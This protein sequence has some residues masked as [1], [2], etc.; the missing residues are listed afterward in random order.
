MLSNRT[1]LVLV[2]WAAHVLAFVFL[3]HLMGPMVVALAML[4]VVVTG[5]LFGTWGGLFSGLMA[6]LLNVLLMGLF[7]GTSR[8]MMTPGGLFGSVHI[9]LLGAGVGWLRNM[10]KQMRQ[11]LTERK[12]MEEALRE[13][14]EMLCTITASAQ[15]AIIMIDEKGDVSFWNE[16]AEKMFGYT[17]AEAMGRNVH[18]LIA[19]ERYHEAH[20]RAF[21]RFQDT[22]QGSAVGKTTELVAVRKGG[23]E[24]PVELSLSAVRL[25]GKWQAISVIRDITERKLV[26]EALQAER[27]KAQKYLDVAGVM[28]VALNTAGEATL[29]NKR[30]C[31]ILGYEPEEI[32]GKNWF[33]NFLPARIRDEVRGVFHRLI[34]G[35]IAPVEYFENPVLTREREERIIAWHN[36][37][38][39]D[40]SGN[41]VG[42][43]GSGE[44]I[45]ER[46]QAEEYMQR[47]HQELATLYALAQAL[48]SS[49]ELQDLL[50]EAL[51]RTVHALGFAGGLIT[52]VDG[53]K[54]DQELVS[55]I[56]VSPACVERLRNEGL[57]GTLCDVVYHN[58]EVL[59][60]EDL[61]QGSSLDTSRLVEAGIQAY[62]G[63]PIVHKDR[64]LGVLCLFDTRPHPVAEVDKAL[65]TSIGQQIGVAVENARLF[66][67]TRRRA[68]Q[69]AALSEIGRAVG[70]TLDLDAV[71]H[72]ILE[73]LERVI[74]YDTASLW[75]RE[76][77]ML[78]IYAV[79]G[80]EDP[81]AVVGLTVSIQEDELFQ[82]IMRTRR[83]LII[84]DAQQD[85]RFH[86]FAGT[87]WVRS[88]L[89]VPLLSKNEVVG[90]LTIDRSEPDSHTAETA[91][92]ALAFGQQ[93]AMAIENARLF[94]ETSQRVR[95][96]QVLNDVSMAAVSG[97]SLDE[98]LKAAA[99]AI[100]NW[101]RCDHVGI[102]LLDA[103][104]GVLR[105]KA[106]ATAGEFPDD[107]PE[108]EWPISQ[109]ITGWVVHH[110]EPVL[111][112]D[113]RLDPRYPG[114]IGS[115]VSELCVPL[116][117]GSR[118]IGTVNVESSQLNA[119]TEDDRRLLST[120]ANN[121]AMRIEQARLLEETQR[122]MREFQLLH[123]V[124]LAAAFGVG[125]DETLQAAAEALADGLKGP[126]VSLMLLDQDS[127]LLQVK[128]SVG[129]PPETVQNLRLGV[130]EG[131]SGWV[132]QHGEP[133]L[134]PDVR[135]DPRY[136]EVA[137]E[138]RSE[139][140]VPLIVS[141]QVIGVL[142]IESPVVNAFTEED[143]RLLSILAHSLALL[144]ERARLFEESRRARQQAE[145][146]V[147]ELQVLH[148]LSRAISGTLDLNQVL[149]ALIG[150]LSQEMGFTHIALH[151][152]DEDANEIRTVRAA[153]LAR[154]ME[155]LVRSLDALAGDI[156]MD[157]AHRGEIEV[158]DGWDERFD[159]E[160]FE[161]EGHADLVRAFVPLVLRGKTI[162]VLEVGYRRD[163][164]AVIAEEEV[165]L[166]GGLADQLAVVIEHAR[167]YEAAEEATRAKSEFLANM[168][169]EIRTP[170]NAII[171][172]TG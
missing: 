50:D 116:L 114:L 11:E 67:E 13:G 19:P 52:L 81:A 150:A 154:S 107:M 74:P 71:L 68:T 40:E 53:R 96:L 27:D 137:V 49:L 84:A 21:A 55:Y 102:A 115:T 148:K 156:L 6:F 93:A 110:G 103:E 100:L 75:L 25:R 170:L 99:E 165:R 162:G 34:A 80:F 32:I 78:H 117:V 94:A 128:A 73:Q 58:G 38:L 54:G 121:L 160:I 62:V 70:S 36:T 48:S 44:D 152:I 65:L 24:F 135:L 169:H 118:V 57:S 139:I 153:G 120:L 145:A 133:V 41:I 85:E 155:G 172:M 15:D 143:Q 151:L 76:G 1:V 105:R 130:G 138:T 35:E 98:A 108:A 87:S 45:T 51:S 69:L 125:L 92:L 3:H 2:L 111:V 159:R 88:W 95:E 77:E 28:F 132:A 26:E 129:Y 23:V 63:I 127:G 43:L 72:L 29:I 161:R 79:K 113:V 14:E 10:D 101:L 86:G 22:G 167:L 171:G 12:Q 144:I 91:G 122:R 30:G 134:V 7:M 42:T 126:R 106:C 164:R 109:G 124:S 119:F 37:V 56:G 166:L 163:E 4:P 142:N 64:V 131:I 39:R 157:V 82:E 140:C 47:R 9:L 149:D 46:R 20:F 59:C 31:E 97:V 60:L 5:W 16:A 66:E 158:L 146:R 89:G 141:S 112:P 168:S 123:E 17:A 147:R 61:H 8:D 90:L 83:P 18:K 136:Y 104:K 33:E